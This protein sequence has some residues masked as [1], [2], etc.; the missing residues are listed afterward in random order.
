[1]K[2]Y[3][4]FSFTFTVMLARNISTSYFMPEMIAYLQGLRVTGECTKVAPGHLIA[5][6]VEATNANFYQSKYGFKR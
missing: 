2:I 6:A 3:R 5:Q 1:M 4:L